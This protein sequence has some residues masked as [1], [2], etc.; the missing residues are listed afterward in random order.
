MCGAERPVGVPLAGLASMPLSVIR[1]A[2]PTPNSQATS[3]SFL[4]TTDRPPNLN[5]SILPVNFPHQYRQEDKTQT[6]PFPFWLLPNLFLF[7]IPNF[8]QEVITLF[9]SLAHPILRMPTPGPC[10]GRTLRLVPIR[11]LPDP[12]HPRAQGRPCAFRR[13]RLHR[14]RVLEERPCALTQE[15]CAGQ[16]VV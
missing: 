6:I 5:L 2:P 1:K 16:Q 4:S 12:I 9:I 8:W 10:A 14:V 13:G 3:I 15:H 7:F 11:P